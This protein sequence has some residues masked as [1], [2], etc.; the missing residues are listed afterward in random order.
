VPT[1]DAVLVNVGV[2]EPLLEP[3]AYTEA[4]GLADLEV[5]PIWV[6]EWP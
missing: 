4:D 2:P 5:D 3:L 6:L 1:V